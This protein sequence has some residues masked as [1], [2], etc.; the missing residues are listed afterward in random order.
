MKLTKGK[1]IAIGIITA[2]VL[3]LGAATIFYF[4][5]KV[6]SVTTGFVIELGDKF[7]RDPFDYVEGMEWSVEKSELDFSKVDEQQVGEYQVTLKH[8]WQEFTYT[9]T[10]QDTTPPKLVLQQKDYYLQQG[11]T[12]GLDFFFDSYF[13]LS[14]EADISLE[15]TQSISKEQNQ[16]SFDKNGLFQIAVTATDPSGNY[17]VKHAIV[18]VDTPPVVKGMQEHYLAVGCE[19]DFLAGI[20]ALDE[21]D[22]DVTSTVLVD[23]SNLDNQTPGDYTVTYRAVDSFGFEGESV[24]TVHILDAVAL[25]DKISSHEIDRYQFNIVGAFNLYDAGYYEAD[26]VDFIQDTLE[27]AIVR[28]TRPGKSYGS[29]F[30]IRITE[31]DVII[32]TNQHV[33]HADKK[34]DVSFHDGS[35]YKG[36][37]VARHYNHDIAFVKVPISDIDAKVFETLRTVHVDEGY[38][39]NLDNSESIS[40]CIRTINDK[41][42]V[43]RDRNGTMLKKKDTPEAS[44]RNLTLM[45]RMDMS[46]FAGSSGSAVLD[47]HGRLIGMVTMRVSKGGKYISFWAITLEDIL[48][49]YEET[50]QTPVNYH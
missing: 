34:L 44:Y 1:K 4:C 16:V 42:Q 14:G 43:W 46:V 30:I 6:E 47:G 26:D 20:T 10:I 31:E 13:D 24:A 49:F 17:T 27:V 5:Y 50:F 48:D 37:V 8:G 21:L 35:C 28:L 11:H 45:T 36:E 32:C 33:T 41:G 40:I 7:T 19:T 18:L 29:G 2:L 23:A 12:Y 15:A 22:G 25:Q 39:R 38:W 9:M 3:M